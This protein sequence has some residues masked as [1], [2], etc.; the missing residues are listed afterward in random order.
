MRPAP[1]VSTLALAASLLL[2]GCAA[3]RD[4]PPA[5]AA[6]GA[7]QVARELPRD[8]RPRHYSIFAAP[9]AANLRLTG[10]TEVDIEV[11]EAT[12]SI[13]LNAAELEFGEVS[14][15][16]FGASDGPPLALTPQTSLDAAA[17]TATFRFAR[18]LAPGRYRLTLNYAGRIH[19][20][21]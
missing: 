2:G 3:V 13:T 6:I 10:R 17:Q 14:I 5:T 1:R 20:Q 18:R 21:P 15:G 11:L 12:D 16:S 19:P 4:E 8:V 9:D 7:A